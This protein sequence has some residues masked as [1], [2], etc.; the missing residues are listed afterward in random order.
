MSL[1]TERDE[2][3]DVDFIN[4]IS[5]DEVSDTQTMRDEQADVD[6]INQISFDEVSDT[7]QIEEPLASAQEEEEDVRFIEQISL[8]A[9]DT[10]EER[11]DEDELDIEPPAPL[12]R[13]SRDLP[14]QVIAP[15]SRSLMAGMELEKDPTKIS[16]QEWAADDGRMKL[17]REFFESRYG[18][19]G[20][21]KEEMSN[22]EYLEEFLTY[23]RALE[24]NFINL[25]QEV[26]WI[27][28]A[29]VKDRDKLVDLYIDVEN[30]IPGFAQEG[31]GST[32]S[33][34][35]D[36]F[37]FN[38]TDPVLLLT[39]LVGRFFTKGALETI[40]QTLKTSGRAAALKEAKKIGA[41]RGLIIGGT[42]EGSGEAARN[43]GTQR[44]QQAHLTQEEFEIEPIQAGLSGFI[45]G[46]L[47]AFG[48]REFEKGRMVSSIK[49]TDDL[50]QK[51]KKDAQKYKL[52]EKDKEE[53]DKIVDNIQ[54]KKQNET[55]DS[56]E[57]A[58]DVMNP[59][60]GKKLLDDLGNAE[61]LDLLDVKVRNDV[62][63]RVTKVAETI[64]RQHEELGTIK[65]LANSMDMSVDD[66]T[67]LKVNVM[68]NKIAKLSAA[69]KL[70]PDLLDKAL[71]KAGL[72]AEQF[73]AMTAVSWSE[74][75]RAIGM[76]GSLGKRIQAFRKDPANKEF[77]EAIDLLS[78][79]KR[80][81]YD[82][83]FYKYIVQG[84]RRLDR[85]N[86]AL[87]TIQLGTTAAN[88]F[89]LFGTQTIQVAGNALETAVHHAGRSLKSAA[90]GKSS[91][92]GFQTGLRNMVKDTFAPIL[93][94][95]D[96]VLAQEMTE[97]LTKYNPN[98]ARTIDR[99]VSGFDA[100]TGLSKFATFANHLNMIVDIYGRRAIFAADI[101]KKLRRVGQS[102]DE[103]VARGGELNTD[104]LRD[105]A[106]QSMIATF[107][108][109]PRKLSHTGEGDAVG[110]TLEA[111]GHA[112]VRLVE[113]LPFVPVIGTGEFPFARFMVNALG[114]QLTHSPAGF[115]KEVGV[116]A[117]RSVR[118]VGRAATIGINKMLKKQ[119]DELLEAETPVE[120]M[121]ARDR[122]A[123]GFMGS[124][125][126]YAGFKY[127]EEN[128]DLPAT[129]IRGDNG[130]LYD[131][132][133]FWPTGA[134][135]ALADL[136]VKMR[137]NLRDG[138]SLSNNVDYAQF[139]KDYTGVRYRSGD[140]AGTAEDI[141]SFLIEAM[142]GKEDADISLEQFAD[143]VGNYFGEVSGRSLTGLGFIS[144]IVSFFDEN[145]AVRRDPGQVEGTGFKERVVDATTNRYTYR[146]PLLKQTLPVKEFPTREADQYR[147]DPFMR[148]FFGT[149][150]YAQ[151]NEV[152]K[153]LRTLGKKDF[154]L[155][156]NTGDRTAAS[157]VNKYLGPIIEKELVKLIQSDSYKKLDK[158]R[159][160][161]EIDQAVSKYNQLA[162][163]LGET[164]A[165]EVSG[166]TGPSPF[167]RGRWIKL[168]AKGRALANSVYMD[169]YGKNVQ[170]MQEEEPDRNHLLHG[171]KLGQQMRSR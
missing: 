118:S 82:N 7:D 57:V 34:L 77:V 91:V 81:A 83:W 163:I 66:F 69:R 116:E 76:L 35:I 107:A 166:P 75:G 111:G 140:Y 67:N 38:V 61:N 71:N 133:R 53:S 52:N 49:Q 23:K 56:E 141:V 108:A 64:F 59:I 30:N 39:G 42:V 164:A 112:V 37:W 149:T 95:K 156:L 31:G 129:V 58:S 2:Q 62:L 22:E 115:V 114:H 135:L 48:A 40:K 74:G 68:V 63:S 80:P 78:E 20:I 29:D 168:G 158:V 122:L 120:I 8:D 130:E 132:A 18:E 161:N 90:T 33:A 46:T 101:D 15:K 55:G 13:A 169:T 119:G 136:L 123:K 50:L 93:F 102:Y 24:N 124:A 150:T 6:F 9:M 92:E 10:A 36:F 103:L 138:L 157:H 171:S 148:A 45:G 16:V 113:S 32:K 170:Q 17:L 60:D 26:D 3:A 85:E 131:T 104:T 94:L 72:N 128:Q 147:M 145:E 5:F 19:N 28:T 134:H 154:T 73:E 96:P 160:S 105:S 165:R 21:Q 84:A 142:S 117:G 100:N 144:D 88:V 87:A 109:M 54:R 106:R 110:R 11:G 99:S 86:R 47:G 139:I 152:E 51:R 153:E 25:G 1:E 89:S 151:Y 27:R 4:Q 126:L 159:R 14:P 79:R 121:R 97:Y 146:I 162:R 125:L 167:D 41:K 137:N 65:Q 43:I 155:T 44:V 12:S 127:R 98:I 143:K 70:D